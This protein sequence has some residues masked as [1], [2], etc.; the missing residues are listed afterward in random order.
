MG[1]KTD[2]VFWPLRVRSNLSGVRHYSHARHASVPA[3]SRPVNASI[4][5]IPAAGRSPEFRPP[6]LVCS[7]T[8][9]Y[10]LDTGPLAGRGPGAPGRIGVTT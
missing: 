6:H 2:R 8:G 7:H 3:N 10:H 5:G 4:A 1:L 9:S